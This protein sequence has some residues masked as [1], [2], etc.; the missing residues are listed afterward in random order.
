MSNDLSRGATLHPN[1]RFGHT[2]V[3]VEE[4]GGYLRMLVC[5]GGKA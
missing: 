4:R 2:V 3:V 1:V 5:A